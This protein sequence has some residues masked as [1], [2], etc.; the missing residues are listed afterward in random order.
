MNS[1]TTAQPFA[2]EPRRQAERT[3]RSDACMLEAA[4]ELI[5]ARGT[6]NTTLK[7]VGE[8]AGYSRGLASYRFGSKAGL[9]SFVVRSVAEEWLTE[10]TRVTRGKVGGAALAAAISAH[11]EFVRE[12]PNHVRAFYT[13][14]FEA[15]GPGS[16][17][18]DVVTH[19]H[20]RRQRDVEQWIEQ[21]QAVGAVP[22]E[23]K[24]GQVAD[25]FC[26]SINGIVYHWLLHPD[27]LPRI[28]TMHTDL[29]KSMIALLT[30]NTD[31]DREPTL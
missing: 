14:W 28:R 21:G 11:Y 27:A 31:P 4:T 19:V 2:P 8:M 18:K 20:D 5:V 17:L 29:T 26:A 22:T 7:D 10:L 25:Q 30:P 6:A 9:L 12:A 1:A 3:A 13:L 15:I 23:V 16:V 24:A